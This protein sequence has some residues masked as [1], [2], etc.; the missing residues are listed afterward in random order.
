[1]AT[2]EDNKRVWNDSYEWPQ[3]GEEWSEAWGGA[4]MEW[5][6]V[7]LPRIHAYVPAP[8]TLEI[9]CGRG[10][11]TQFL[12]DLCEELTVVDLSENCI[13]VCRKRFSKEQHISYFV[14]DGIKLDMVPDQSIDFVFSFDSLVHAEPSVIESYVTELARI[15]TP[16]GVAFIHH[17]NLGAYPQYA[18]AQSDSL[19]RKVM[20]AAGLMENKVHWRAEAMTAD[21][22]SDFTASVGLRCISQ[23]LLNWGTKRALIDCLSVIVREDGAMSRPLRKLV[24]PDFMAEAEKW[25]KLSAL[26]RAPN[27]D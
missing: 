17:S 25:R 27:S 3:G 4:Q 16:N 8:K 2:I 21:A 18:S 7:L 5:Y 15:L 11:W 23:E 9:A 14:N 6:G 24:N 10:R 13:E 20:T 19:L 26:Y 12:K 22:M 1:M